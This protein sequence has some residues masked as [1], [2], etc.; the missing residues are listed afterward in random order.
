MRLIMNTNSINN[1]SRQD[2]R[3][4]R[5]RRQ[6]REALTALILEK[7]YDVLTIEDITE[8]ADLGRTTF[9]LH[10]RGKEELLLE[11]ISTTAQELYEQVNAQIEPG[12][13][14]SPQLGLQ[15]VSQVFQHAA[16]NSM[17]YRIIL[18]GGA[19]SKV[20]RFIFEFLSE[21]AKP[22]FE[23]RFI[24]H[25]Q[26]SVPLEVITNYFSA[27]MLGF[28]TWWLEADMPYTAEE[29]AGYFTT[30]FLSGTRNLPED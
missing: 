19:A 22:Y 23:Q 24:T 5:T 15:A 13:Q 28:L 12:M 17:L 9:Y 30:M 6:L 25:S 27:A 1:P 10:Y 18:K 2:R 16:Q 26:A 3:V 4:N 20:Q 14:H 29:A 11:S 21:A 8:R 7:G